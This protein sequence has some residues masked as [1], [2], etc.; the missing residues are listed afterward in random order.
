MPDLEETIL[1]LEDIDEDPYRID[2][3]FAQLK[4][5]GI[6]DKINGLVL[7]QFIDCDPKDKSK[8]SLLVEEVVMDYVGNLKIP[9]IS[10]FAYGHGPVKL[11]LP[12]GALARLDT[13]DKSLTIL[14]QVTK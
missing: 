10:N 2:R 14:E 5:A 3:Y 6:F 1:V 13:A 12:I 7:G 9:I 11:T 4:L 8:P